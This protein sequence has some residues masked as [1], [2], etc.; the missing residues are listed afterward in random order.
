MGAQT[1]MND[2]N[3]TT[4][5]ESGEVPSKRPS[6]KARL[7]PSNRN[8]SRRELSVE[9]EEQRP[10]SE[11]AGTGD[12]TLLASQHGSLLTQRNKSKKNWKGLRNLLPKTSSRSDKEH[13]TNGN[14]DE[15]GVTEEKV[16]RLFSK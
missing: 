13:I 5:D 7:L 10:R 11:V 8:S 6:W 14:D 4:N 12:Q 9:R 1:K 3:T 2:I 15:C 16:S